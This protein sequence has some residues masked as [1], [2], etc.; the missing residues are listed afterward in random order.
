MTAGD[1]RAVVAGIPVRWVTPRS[2]GPARGVALWLPYL[3]G[4]KDLMLPVLER[5]A[6]AGF[7]AV[8]LDPDQHGERGTEPPEQLRDR[9]LGSFRREMWPVIGQTT[10]DAMRVLDWASA[11][12]GVHGVVAGGLSMG[13]DISV[14]LAGIDHRVRRVAALGSTPDWRRP[15]MRHLDGSGVLVDQGTPSPF[16]Q[17]LHDQLNPATHVERYAHGPDILFEHGG[18]DEHVPVEAAH[19]FAAALAAAAPSGAQPV[20]VRV[21]AGLRHIDSVRNP[22][23]I[24]RCLRWLMAGRV[25]GDGDQKEPGAGPSGGASVFSNQ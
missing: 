7:F 10:L 19:R 1:Q 17:W 15:G 3:G 24:D 16:G 20:T 12:H 18:A 13:G 21:T 6:E 14:A 5:L 22:E 11:Q 4:S 9:M 2:G 8:S 23:A 25:T